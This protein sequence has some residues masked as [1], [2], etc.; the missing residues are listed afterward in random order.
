M[1]QPGQKDWAAGKAVG[2][3]QHSLFWCWS[4][5][6][7]SKQLKMFKGSADFSTAAM[8]PWLHH[9]LSA[10]VLLPQLSFWIVNEKICPKHVGIWDAYFEWLDVSALQGSEKRKGVGFFSCPQGPVW[11]LVVI[12]V[13]QRWGRDTVQWAL[14]GRMNV[15]VHPVASSSCESRSAKQALPVS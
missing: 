7:Y 8:E 3:S 5:V 10:L 9:L 12:Q 14:G 2:Q 4:C 6:A 13:R 1:L 11:G 15:A